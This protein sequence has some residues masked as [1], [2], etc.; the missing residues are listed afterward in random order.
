[1]QSG[2]LFWDKAGDDRKWGSEMATIN[3]VL[4]TPGELAD[5]ASTRAGLSSYVR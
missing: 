1:M 4:I 2:Q 5:Q 3:W